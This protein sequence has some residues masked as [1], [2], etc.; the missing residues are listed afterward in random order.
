MGYDEATYS[1]FLDEAKRLHP[2]YNSTQLKE[3][4]VYSATH[5]WN[6]LHPPVK[7]APS[8]FSKIPWSTLAIVF[9]RLAVLGLL[10]L[11]TLK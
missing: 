6:R 5:Y 7:K 8:L 1:R 10:C 11:L 4:A 2:K 3:W 9:Y